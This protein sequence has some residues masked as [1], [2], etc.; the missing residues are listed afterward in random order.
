M[1][2]SGVECFC[3]YLQL[4]V[5]TESDEILRSVNHSWQLIIYYYVTEQETH[6]KICSL[7]YGIYLSGSVSWV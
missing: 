4:P 2:K 3:H 7:W 6:L 5:C 1:L